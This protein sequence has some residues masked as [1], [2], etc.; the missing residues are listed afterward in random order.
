MDAST[1]DS[2]TL[3]LA[4]NSPRRRELLLRL[5][6]AFQ[7]SPQDIDESVLDA[8]KPYAYVQRVALA[9]AQSALVENPD[10][11]ILAADTSVIVDDQIL[12]KPKDSSDAAFMLG[13]L[14][15]RKHSVLTAI[16]LANSSQQRSTVVQ[17]MVS[18][19]SISAAEM[20]SY[21]E[22]GEP[23]GKAGAYAIQGFGSAF[24][25]SIEGSF[26]NVVGLPLFET[27]QFLQE[28]GVA[29]WQRDLVDL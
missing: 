4:S 28:F 7:V 1:V 9:K 10:R 20:Q 16:T 3:L 26:S 23:V 15:N 22:T 25:K 29:I 5:G 24:V 14:S 21:W 27:A 17:T 12:G 19:R 8:E 6:V 18:F 2:T 13:L 11:L